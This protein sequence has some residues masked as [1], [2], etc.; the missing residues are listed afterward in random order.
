[1]GKALKDLV[2]DLKEKIEVERA[3]LTK[4]A[5][6]LA[7]DADPL[8]GLS[9]NGVSAFEHAAR[10][11]IFT[12]IIILVEAAQNNRS[13]A[14]VIALVKAEALRAVLRAVKASPST[15][16]TANLADKAEGA[17]WAEILEFLN[18]FVF[19]AETA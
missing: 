15:N 19:A 6:S 10:V 18:F 2:T 7:A 16:P 4:F 11:R 3:S 13:N 14:E 17:A 1:M 8:T 5:A 9:W 12:R